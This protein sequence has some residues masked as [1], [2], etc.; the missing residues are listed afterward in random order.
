MV[1]MEKLKAHTASTASAAGRASVVICPV[2]SSSLISSRAQIDAAKF[3]RVSPS[4][5]ECR[6][7]EIFLRSISH[8]LSLK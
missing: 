7:A 5:A 3:P 8:A 2:R 4:V 6:P 1:T